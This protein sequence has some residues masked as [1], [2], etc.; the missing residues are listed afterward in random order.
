MHQIHRDLLE[1]DQVL[2]AQFQ[3]AATRAHNQI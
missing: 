2:C 1:S 3:E